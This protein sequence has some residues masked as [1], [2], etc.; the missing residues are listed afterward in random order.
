LRVVVQAAAVL[1]MLVYVVVACARLSYPFEL[2]WLEGGSLQQVDRI[3]SGRPIY[4]RPDLSFVAFFY[5][6]AYYYVAAAAATLI[7]PG[8]L[9]LR[10]V[11]LLASLGSL[12]VIFS[13]VRRDT[14][15]VPPALMAA[16]LFAATFA[17]SGGWFDLARVDSLYVCLLL[18]A[19]YVLRFGRPAGVAVLFGL[20]MDEAARG[21]SSSSP[22]KRV[23]LEGFACLA[24]LLQFASLAYDPLRHLPSAAD[25]RAGQR[26]VST[27]AGLKGDVLLPYHPYLLAR[28]GKKVHAHH[29]PLSAIVLFGDDEYRSRLVSEVKRALQAREYEA[30]VLD[31]GFLFADD[32]ARHYRLERRLWETEGAF[33]PVTGNPM[34]PE[35]L[36]VPRPNP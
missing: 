17:A 29:L 30:I 12:A 24:A 14:G 16:G 31:D 33:L 19:A 13:F 20:G 25:R 35:A 21:A 22:S 4:A 9:P 11:S 26:L 7:G 10:L 36:Y 3:L 23:A 8:F 34:K 5:T 18:L 32:V 27:L 28:A 2:E 1:Y 6:P 15:R